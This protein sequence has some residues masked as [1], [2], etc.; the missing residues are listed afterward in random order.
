MKIFLLAARIRCCLVRYTRSSGLCQSS[1]PDLDLAKVHHLRGP[2]LS[3]LPYQR[4]GPP[5][6]PMASY[7]HAKALR[8]QKEFGPSP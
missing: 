7:E 2:W 4:A 3:Q 6:T 8:L 5:D 1:T